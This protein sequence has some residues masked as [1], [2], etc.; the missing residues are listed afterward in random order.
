[1][2]FGTLASLI[3]A[4]AQPPAA[5]P[6][7]AAAPENREV[8]PS[9]SFATVEPVLAQIVCTQNSTPRTMPAEELAEVAEGIFGVDRV[10]VAPR[11]EDAIDRAATLAEQGGTYGE[12]IGSGGVLVT[13]SVITVGEARSMLTRKAKS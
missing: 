4:A 1:M 6:F 7:N 11:L 13:G 9:F 3:L 8:L 5:G 2:S 12:A 10:H